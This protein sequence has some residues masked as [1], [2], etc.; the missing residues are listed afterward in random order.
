ML[1]TFPVSGTV[2]RLKGSILTLSFL[3]CNGALIPSSYEV[4]RDEGREKQSKYSMIS[5]RAILTQSQIIKST[6][7]GPFIVSRLYKKW[8]RCLL[9]WDAFVSSYAWSYS[10]KL[11]LGQS[12]PL[13]NACSEYAFTRGEL[14]PEANLL[15]QNGHELNMSLKS[16]AFLILGQKSNINLLNLPMKQNCSLFESLE[17]KVIH[18]TLIE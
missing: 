1:L 9:V 5:K 12:L 10:C 8:W 16:N 3:D 17:W 14:S 18:L 6:M 4:W 15:W 2:F 7:K 11:C 13:V